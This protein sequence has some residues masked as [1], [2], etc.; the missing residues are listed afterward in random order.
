MRGKSIVE[1]LLVFMI[2]YLIVWAYGSTEFATLEL[3]VLRW[4]YFASFL[5][6]LIPVSILLLTRRDFE[7]Y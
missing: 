4:S 1:V 2:F 7:S 3:D 5:M 6:L